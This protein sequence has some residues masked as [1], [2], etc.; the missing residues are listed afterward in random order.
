[1]GLWFVILGRGYGLYFYYIVYCNVKPADRRDRL[2]DLLAKSGGEGLALMQESS[3]EDDEKQEVFSVGT[4]E[5]LR[6]RQ[7]IADY[8]LPR[9]VYSLA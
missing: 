7:W 6:A 5:L 4:L 8:S 3:D 2:R 9:Y 1:M